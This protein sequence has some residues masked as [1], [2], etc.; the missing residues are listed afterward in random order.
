MSLLLSLRGPAA[1]SSFRVGKLLEGFG[2]GGI[3]SVQT[4]FWHFV[5]LRRPLAE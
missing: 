3:A 1:L 4:E 5:K 2:P